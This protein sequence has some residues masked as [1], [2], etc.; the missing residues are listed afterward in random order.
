VKKKPVTSNK[1]TVTTKLARWRSSW[2]SHFCNLNI[3]AATELHGEPS[4]T[5]KRNYASRKSYATAALCVGG[6]WKYT[7]TAGSSFEEHMPKLLQF[8]KEVALV[9]ALRLVW[10]CFGDEMEACMLALMR[11][12][13]RAA[14]ETT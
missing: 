12:L 8:Q 7:L 1:N 14:Y 9:L 3:I 6:P 5:L 4:F 13:I 11:N 2:Y 10:A